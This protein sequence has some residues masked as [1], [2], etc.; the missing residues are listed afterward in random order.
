MLDSIQLKDIS[1]DVTDKCTNCFDE[2]S[3]LS[4]NCINTI[5]ISLALK[6]V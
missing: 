5:K 1:R 4:E 2:L 6:H 3:D